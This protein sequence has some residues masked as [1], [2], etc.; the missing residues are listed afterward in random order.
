[1]TL[2]EQWT[3]EGILKGRLEGK[4]NRLQRTIYPFNGIN[5]CQ[6]DAFQEYCTS[7]INRTTLH[8][9]NSLYRLGWELILKCKNSGKADLIQQF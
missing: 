1:M 4:I 3:Q 7:L 2:A 6:N 8:I 5:K 9:T